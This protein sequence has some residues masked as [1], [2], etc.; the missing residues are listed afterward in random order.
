MADINQ[1]AEWV[2]ARLTELGNATNEGLNTLVTSNNVG[3][4]TAANVS[5]T[6]AI[7]NGGTGASNATDA[8][9][10]LGITPQNIGAVPASGGTFT[11][12]VTVDG[13]VAISGDLTVGGENVMDSIGTVAS[14]LAPEYSASSTYAVG[15]YVLYNS[16]LHE[17][18]TPIT[19]AE[20]WT[21][22]HWSQ[23]TVGKEL[24]TLTNTALNLVSG[25]VEYTGYRFIT[26]AINSTGGVN[27]TTSTRLR[28][29]GS[30][31]P[32]AEKGDILYIEPE[33]NGI[34][35]V[36][37]TSTMS[38]ANFYGWIVP[39]GNRQNG[40]IPIPDSVEGKY[41]AIALAKVGHES[42]DISGDASIVKDYVHY[43]RTSGS[44]IN[45][46]Q[47]EI[48]TINT[49]IDKFTHD[50]F[51]PDDFVMFTDI[52]AKPDGWWTESGNHGANTYVTTELVPVYPGKTYYITNKPS[53][54][55]QGAFFDKDQNFVSQLALASVIKDEY[56][57]ANGYLGNI[58]TSATNYLGTGTSSFGAR[59]GMFHFTVPDG[60]YYIS[61]NINAGHLFHITL[62][63]KPIYGINTFWQYNRTLAERVMAMDTT[64]TD[65]DWETRVSGRNEVIPFNDVAYQT[66]NKRKLCVIGPSTVMIDRRWAE[67]TGVNL[68]QWIAGWQEYLMPYY[69]TVDSYGYSGASWGDAYV[70]DDR[71]PSIHTMV[72]TYDYGDRIGLDLSGYD[73]FMIQ[74]STNGLAQTEVGEWDT[75]TPDTDTYFGALRA[76][77]DYIFEQNP[78]AK[79]Y[80]SQMVRAGVTDSSKLEDIE[81]INPEL[82]GMCYKLGLTLVPFATVGLNASTKTSDST[83][84]AG[85]T[86]DGTHYNQ[87]G[88][89]EIAQ[90]MKKTLLS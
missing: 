68:E 18:T 48:D 53:N 54:G 79:V 72:C 40:L 12:D 41:I 20:A 49:T 74:G 81:A 75:A 30:V 90:L 77:I 27:S 67:K 78:N 15:D 8:R 64:I 43:Y 56:K 22:G 11:G 59:A 5:G 55:V 47:S 42:E 58:S 28:T 86:Y 19:T 31:N 61:F 39:Y 69:D 17:C 71:F 37:N 45:E 35:A 89:Y 83:G 57:I 4:Y 36:Y 38:A 1:T 9:E 2:T 32:V 70:Y 24:S 82:P 34:V 44:T 84:E 76:T 51:R 50:G 65:E 10:N 23:V 73:D 60:C 14:N 33:Y 13:D 85:W 66:Y 46:L 21:A 25:G 52:A 88:S 80:V 29:L 63:S 6:V 87:R 3:N 16:I 7:A 26:G 62:C